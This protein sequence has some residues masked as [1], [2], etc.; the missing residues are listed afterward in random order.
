MLVNKETPLV[1]HLLPQFPANPGEK[2]VCHLDP[3]V[4]VV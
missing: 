1:E 2:Q 3:K 4:Y